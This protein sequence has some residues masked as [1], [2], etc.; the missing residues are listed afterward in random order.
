VQIIYLPLDDG[1]MDG[2]DQEC[3]YVHELL[4]CTRYVAF[5]LS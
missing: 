4:M 5:N 2:P 1:W 3:S